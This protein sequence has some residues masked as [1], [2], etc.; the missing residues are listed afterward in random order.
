MDLMTTPVEHRDERLPES[1]VAATHRR[2]GT[3]KALMTAARLAELRAQLELLHGH[4]RGEIAQRLREARTYGDGSNNDEYHAL[5]EEQMVTEARV[6]LLENTVANAVV[7]DTSQTAEGVAA[8]GSTITIEDTASGR[9]GRYRL[10]SAHEPLERDVISAASP[11]G[12][13]LMGVAP[14]TIVTVELPK[15]RYR[16]VRLLSTETAG[17]AVRSS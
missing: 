1:R 5:R 16:T 11:V 9:E 12:Q 4:E 13:A 6:A 2:S 14:G 7:I 15:G 3:Q 10:G 8:I 17:S